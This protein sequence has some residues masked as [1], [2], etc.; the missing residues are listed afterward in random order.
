MENENNVISICYVIVNLNNRAE[1]TIY[2]SNPIA[3][4]KVGE[5]ALRFETVFDAKNYIQENL[6]DA[7]SI[8]IAS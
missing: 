7:I 8:E 3:L 4:M 1:P 2:L 6:R 5:F